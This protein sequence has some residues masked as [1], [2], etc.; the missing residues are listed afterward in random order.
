VVAGR[1]G[2]EEELIAGLGERD[3]RREQV[4]PERADVRGREPCGEHARPD[5]GEVRRERSRAVGLEEL[6][7]GGAGAQGGTAGGERREGILAADD[8]AEE[9]D[10]RRRRPPAIG[11]GQLDAVD[12]LEHRTR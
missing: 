2:R 10:E 11:H 4:F 7:R 8:R 1:H 3:P 6:D 5:V 12:A 9:I